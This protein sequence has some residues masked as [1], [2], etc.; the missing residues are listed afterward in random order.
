M[1]GIARAQAEIRI[2]FAHSLSTIEPAHQAA[3]FFARNVAQRTANHVR[4]EVSPGEQLGSGR[5]VIPTAL[6]IDRCPGPFSDG[7]D[8]PWFCDQFVPS[9]AAGV[10]D[11]VVIVPDGNAEVVAA[12]NLP[13]VLDRV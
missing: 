11:G 13:D 5:D 1:P 6:N 2:R 4:I 3:E 12:K 8:A 10:D 7:G 9:V